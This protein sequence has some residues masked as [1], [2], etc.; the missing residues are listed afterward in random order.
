MP[1]PEQVA[2]AS[3]ANSESEGPTEE[4]K[5]L[6][7]QLSESRKQSKKFL[8]DSLESE[9]L[10][11]EVGSLREMVSEL[12]GVIKETAVVEEG[13]IEGVLK[14]AKERSVSDAE[15]SQY[16]GQIS[17]IIADNDADWDGDE[18]LVGAREAWTKGDLSGALR[19]VEKAFSTPSGSE[20]ALKS[21][22]QTELKKLGV[23]VDVGGTPAVPAAAPTGLS[24]YLDILNDPK[25]AM[26]DRDKLLDEA[27]KP[28][29]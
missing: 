12:A 27:F 20:E 6:Q 10:R 17:E 23:S 4:F 7:R 1:G 19:E 25:A 15:A 14:R 3:S 29:S 16:Q 21:M 2:D 13:D 26:Q 22:V 8:K 9:R 24:S 18:N 11:S 28:R 5:N